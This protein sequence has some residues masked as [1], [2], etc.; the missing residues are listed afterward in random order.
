MKQME[1]TNKKYQNIQIT[2]NIQIS[3]A[4]ILKDSQIECK[5]DDDE[6]EL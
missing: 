1:E 5:F 6:N 2:Q 4:S 3:V